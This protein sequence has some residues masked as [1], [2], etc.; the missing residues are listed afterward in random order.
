METQ[1][2]VFGDWDSA[3][4]LPSVFPDLDYVARVILSKRLIIQDTA[5]FNR[6]SRAHRGK[7]KTN[8]G[9]QWISIPILGEERKKPLCESKPTF[10]DE[11]LALIRRVLESNYG[12]A[13]WFHHFG[14]EIFADLE[15]LQ[16]E[17]SSAD[18]MLHFCGRLFNYLDLDFDF[19][20]A[21]DHQD[22]PSTTAEICEA[23]GLD[24]YLPERNGMQFQTPAA[25]MIESEIGLPT[26]AQRRTPFLEGCSILDLLFEEGRDSWKI[27]ELIRAMNP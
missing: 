2:N 24:T 9:S 1:K 22:K 26:Y 8:A 21:S 20:K 23:F 11:W 14:P 5:F 10:D 18:A 12:S 7:V 13:T 16:N 19:E 6:K 4:L 27:F 17:T 15:N 3:I 25:G